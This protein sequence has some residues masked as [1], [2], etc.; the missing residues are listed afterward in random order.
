M[1]EL[2]P[3]IENQFA[4]FQV[5]Y[6][7]LWGD[8]DE[9]AKAARQSQVVTDTS[10]RSFVRACYAFMEGVVTRAETLATLIRVIRNEEVPPKQAR[11]MLNGILRQDKN[12][13]SSVEHD[14]RNFA[15]RVKDSFKALSAAT[16]KPFDLSNQHREWA[17]FT[18]AVKIRDRITH[19]K[20][21]ED[22]AISNDELLLI[23]R[24]G[25]WFHE[26]FAAVIIGKG[27]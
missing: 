6:E 8:V 13:V 23:V 18:V 16:E 3:I 26:Q 21:A 7:L 14:K 20:I 11:T 19:P 5:M 12:Q 22:L 17:D 2:T 15:S 4:N 27:V 9:T 25:T 1:G 10:R 24:S